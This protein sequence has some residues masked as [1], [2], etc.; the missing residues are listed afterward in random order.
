MNKNTKKSAFLRLVALT[1]IV[2]LA[3]GSIFSAMVADRALKERAAVNFQEE[4]DR[5][6][7]KI[8]EKLD[9]Y[10]DIQYVSRAYLTSSEN[11][12]Q[13]E[14]DKF[15]REQ[16]IFKRNPGIS[17]VSFLRFFG[18]DQKAAFLKKMRAQEFFGGPAFDIRPAGNREKYAVLELISTQ[19]DVRS[20]FGLDT[21]TGTPQKKAMDLALLT[22]RQHATEPFVLGTGVPGFAMYLPV[23]KDNAHMGYSLLS[24]RTTDL[25]EA[26]LDTDNSSLRYKITDITDGS[27]ELFQSG[28]WNE[29]A[30]LKRSDRVD[31]AGRTWEITYASDNRSG[32]TFLYPLVPLLILAVG[33]LVTIPLVAAYVY[34]GRPD[35]TTL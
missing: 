19:N 34:Y 3:G 1:A 26:L 5:T 2:M 33:A 25:I 27:E 12:T 8:L 17:T 29:K 16:S 20:S 18:N 28:N 31:V 7:D 4:A 35:N 24:F 11:V 9:D 21:Y 10:A 14:W 6:S 22:G 23:Y 15:F 30:P 32:N 13:E